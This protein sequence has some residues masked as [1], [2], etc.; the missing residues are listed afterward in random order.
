MANNGFCIQSPELI[1][2][3][4]SLE[5]DKNRI[6]CQ[7]Y[8]LFPYWKKKMQVSILI[9]GMLRVILTIFEW[10][11]ASGKPSQLSNMRGLG[12]K[13]LGWKWESGWSEAPVCPR[14]DRSPAS[15][16]PGWLYR[17]FLAQFRSA[18]S[19]CLKQ[20][21]LLCAKTPLFSFFPII[22]NLCWEPYMCFSYQ[23]FNSYNHPEAGVIIK[24]WGTDVTWLMSGWAGFGHEESD[25][26]T[27]SLN[28]LLFCTL[29]SFLLLHH[30]L[31]VEI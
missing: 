4:V 31:E 13:G 28:H 14:P 27:C 11:E 21:D 1:Y 23:L 17:L 5:P 18:D 12:G 29:S 24:D 3:P 26:R 8:C 22:A 30:I 7:E 15:A 25:A 16:D 10:L 9:L 20:M 6:N 19:I 2:L